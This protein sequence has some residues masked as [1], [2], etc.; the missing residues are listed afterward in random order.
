[1]TLTTTTSVMTVKDGDTRWV[2]WRIPGV[3]L[4]GV[5]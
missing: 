4:D 2:R 5:R 1:M 3:D